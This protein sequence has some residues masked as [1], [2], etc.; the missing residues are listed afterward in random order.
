[1][2]GLPVISRRMCPIGQL[3]VNATQLGYTDFIAS[4]EDYIDIAVNTA[5]D[6]DRRIDFRAKRA[7][8]VYSKLMDRNHFISQFEK[9]IL[10]IVERKQQADEKYK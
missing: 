7:R 5:S 10:S 4:T 1:M 3:G 2:D 8:H 6:L 9:L